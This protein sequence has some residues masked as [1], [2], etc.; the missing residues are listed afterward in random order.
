MSSWNCSTPEERIARW[1]EFRDTISNED[2]DVLLNSIAQFFADVPVG[3]RSID[4]YTPESWPTPWEILYHKLFCANSISLLIYYTL[5]LVLDEDR[6]ELILIDD[7]TDRFIVPLLDK[8]RILNYV[9][10][11]ISNTDDFPQIA[12]IEEFAKEEIRSFK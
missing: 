6:V 7:D 8:K 4:F 12:I 2:E 9:L 5:T 10:G 11:E 3:A 1:K